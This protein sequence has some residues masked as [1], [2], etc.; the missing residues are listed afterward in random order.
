[1]YRTHIREDGSLHLGEQARAA[2]YRPG[3]LVD[4]ALSSTGTLYVSAADA[5]DEIEL[6]A[7]RLPAGPARQTVIEGRQA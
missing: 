3:Q 2:G 4:V 6:H 5:P 7:L 1:M